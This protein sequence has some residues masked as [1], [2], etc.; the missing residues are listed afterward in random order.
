MCV[1]LNFVP[2]EDFFKDQTTNIKK[3]NKV[4]GGQCLRHLN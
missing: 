3:N 4:F 1:R 2:T